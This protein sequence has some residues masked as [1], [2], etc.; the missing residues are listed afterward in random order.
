MSQLELFADTIEPVSTKPTEES[1]RARLDSVLGLLRSV[2]ELPWS[3]RETAK[4][5]LIIPQM[6]DWLPEGERESVRTQFET[7]LAR[8]ESR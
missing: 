3:P 2:S 1:I 5:K 4:W 7:L 6:A 8:L